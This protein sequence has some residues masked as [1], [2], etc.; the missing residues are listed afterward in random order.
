MP[1]DP[2]LW[3]DQPTP[4]GVGVN[5]NNVAKVVN[6]YQWDNEQRAHDSRQA[7][8][9]GLVWAAAFAAFSAWRNNRKASKQTPK[10]LTLREQQSQNY[11]NRFEER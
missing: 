8:E 4:N 11:M 6:R 9:T 5:L 1:I 2:N 10:V 3:Q 7:I